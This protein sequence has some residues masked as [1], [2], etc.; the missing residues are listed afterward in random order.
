MVEAPVLRLP[1]FSKVFEVACDASGIGIGEV[2]SQDGHPVAYFSEKL[3]DAKLKYSTYDQKF[4][5]VIQALHHWRH[6]LL[7]QKFVIFSDHEA[8]KYINSQKKLNSR[9]SRWV[10]FLQDYT[11]TLRHKAGVENKAADTLSRRLAILTVLSNQVV[12]FEKIKTEY[13]SCPD[14]QEIFTLLKS[15]TREIDCF[16]LQNGYLFRFRKLCILRT[17]MRE[18]LVWELHA[19]GLVG[20]FGHNKTIEAVKHHFYWPSLKRDVIKLV[21]RC[22]TCQLAKQ[23]KQNTGLYMPLPDPNRP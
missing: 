19:G 18:F 21:G 11:Y 4:N 6:Y 13:E 8:L 16:L 3:N 9:H 5:A 10:E 2:L 14:F 20:H 15:R 12:G 7:P 23:R 1:D 17:S 22:H